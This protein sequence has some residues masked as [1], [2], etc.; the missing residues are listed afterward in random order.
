VQITKYF[1]SSASSLHFFLTIGYLAIDFQLIFL[2]R[3]GR[4]MT[5]IINQRSVESRVNEVQRTYQCTHYVKQAQVMRLFLSFCK[6]I[7]CVI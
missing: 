4:L 2:Q 1:G 3:I 7:P 6:R 5:N